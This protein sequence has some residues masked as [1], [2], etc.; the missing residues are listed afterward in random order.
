[1]RNSADE[2]LRSRA[3]RLIDEIAEAFADV[4][5]GQGTTLEAAD[6]LD[7]FA[8]EANAIWI[9]RQTAPSDWRDVDIFE[10]DPGFIGPSFMNGE[11]CYFYLPAYM[12]LDL[13]EF[14]EP[15]DPKPK[16]GHFT[17]ERLAGMLQKPTRNARN[18]RRSM[19]HLLITDAQR[20]AIARYLALFFEAGWCD[21]MEVD[22]IN[23][24]GL[25]QAL[26]SGERVRVKSIIDSL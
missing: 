14:I 17:A 7:G 6:A 13:R 21:E 1:M 16:W 10:L 23:T 20:L 9:S 26:P 24:F 25:I 8:S 12:T 2:R 5:I 15:D 3:R 4:K 18:N 22:L 11:G 19:L